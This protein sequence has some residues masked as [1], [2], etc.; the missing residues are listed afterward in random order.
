MKIRHFAIMCCMLSSTAYADNCLDGCPTGVNHGKTLT[1]SIYTL[2]NNAN[3]KFADWA[4]YHVT[5]DSISGPSHSRTWKADPNLNAANTLEPADYQDAY[6]T[7]HTDRGHQVPLGSFSNSKDWRMTNYLSNITPQSS[8]LNQGPWVR[9]ETAVRHY[10][11]Q[12]HD[13][14]VVTGPLYENYFATLP[15]ADENHTIPSG[16]FKVIAEKTGNTITASAFIMEQTAGRRDDYCKTEVTVDEVESRSGIN[17][18]PDLSID[19]ES[20]VEGY[21]GGLTTAL[22]CN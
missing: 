18:M 9:L 11:R 10:V 8:A 22:G 4:A 2:K 12:G 13:V 6:A 17:V 1:R 3:T 16:Y 20:E 7:I 5:Q 21:I 19:E 14:Y 15:K